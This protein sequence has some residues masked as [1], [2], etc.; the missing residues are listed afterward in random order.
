MWIS[1]PNDCV[2]SNLKGAA[3]YKWTNYK[4]LSVEEMGLLLEEMYERDVTV[5]IFK[6]DL[7]ISII[8]QSDF[9][10]VVHLNKKH[11]H[12]T[13]IIHGDAVHTSKPKKAKLN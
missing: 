6:Q 5:V 4:G 10:N 9:K 11:D 1:N 12:S 3:E 8:Q 13:A 2:N 7:V